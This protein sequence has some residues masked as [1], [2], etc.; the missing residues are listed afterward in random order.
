[1]ICGLGKLPITLTGMI[2]HGH[3]DERYAQY[4]NELWPNDPNFTV[5]YLLRCFWILEKALVCE[6]NILFEHPPQNAFFACLLQR[7]SHYTSELKTPNEVV[8]PK[9]LPKNLLLQI[10]N[11][12]KDNKN[13]YLL[14]FLSL[15]MAKYVFGEVKLRFG[16]LTKKLKKQNIDRIN[17]LIC[18]WHGDISFK[19][20]ELIFLLWLMASLSINF[21]YFIDGQ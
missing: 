1:M 16:Y 18:G 7:K 14:A 3:G 12:V 11:Y 10:D 17:N 4:S 9:P 2:V 5:G 8:G 15:L 13:S 19:L 20:Q 21:Y 6:S